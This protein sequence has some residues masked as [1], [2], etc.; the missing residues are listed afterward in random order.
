[1]IEFPLCKRCNLFKLPKDILHDPRMPGGYR[2][3]CKK[4]TAQRAYL[5][6]HGTL[7]GWVAWHTK[8]MPNQPP[9]VLE[10]RRQRERDLEKVRY[11]KD[12]EKARAKTRR[13]RAKRRDVERASQ[14]QRYAEN[15][16]K[17]RK[18]AA[19]WRAN[20]YEK[21]L[22]VQRKSQNKRR[23]NDPEHFREINRD[24]IRRNPGHSTPNGAK[25]R[26]RKRAIPVIDTVTVAALHKRDKG[27]CSLCGK[28][29][30]LKLKFPHPMSATIE[31]IIPVSQEGSEHSFKNT[32]LAHYSCNSSKQNRAVTQQLRLFG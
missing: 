6:Q 23:K 4:C 29:V 31:H 32:A 7:D 28:R 25:Y 27:I 17:Y 22:E 21:A 12:V 5:K 13:N 24:Y 15:P 10:A 8:R 30:S 20:N 11:H 14:R 3:T 19:T 1:M 16:E 26:A 9:E 2:K 18:Q